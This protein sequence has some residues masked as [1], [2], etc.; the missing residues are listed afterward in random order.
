MEMTV[1]ESEQKKILDTRGSYCPGP[2]TELFK[3]YRLAKQGDIIE[4]WATDPAARPDITAW[5]TRTGNQLLEVSQEKDY[6]RIVVKI[7][8]KRS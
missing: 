1:Q 7:T 6:T 3:A 4:V 5:T 8:A 2:L